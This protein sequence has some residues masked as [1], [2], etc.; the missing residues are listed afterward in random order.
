MNTTFK[1]SN[2]TFNMIKQLSQTKRRIIASSVIG[3]LLENF[4]VM[5]C[6][7]L[8]QFIAI[9]FFPSNSFENNIFN[10]FIIF[11]IGY[12]SRPIGSILIGL[13]ADQIGR[14]K[15]LIFSIIMVGVCT[16]IIGVIPSYQSIGITSTILFSFFRILQ[17]ISVGGEYISSIAYLI[18]NAEKK[19]K[20]FLGSWVSVGFNLGS[21]FASL[22]VFILIYLIEESILPTWSWRVIFYVFLHIRR[23][24]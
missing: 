20:G 18:E 19:E 24:N 10:T 2:S 12:L 11:F 15:T 9:T 22:L 14:K 5:I 8:A 17:N 1:P 21:L 3:N 4:D 7:F 6:A 23:L 13:Y 16:A